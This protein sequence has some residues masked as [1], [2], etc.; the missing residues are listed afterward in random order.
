[1]QDIPN[2][3]KVSIGLGNVDNLKQMPIAGGTFT[4]VAKAQ[5]NTSYT[6]GQVRNII[7]SPY[8]ADV[9]VMQNGEIWIKYK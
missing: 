8:D 1:M 4:G 2:P 3:T 6:T 9:N 5:V 7:L